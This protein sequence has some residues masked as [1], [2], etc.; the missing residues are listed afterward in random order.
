M[1]SASER[2]LAA[3]AAD[4]AIVVIDTPPGDLSIVRAAIRAGD[5]VLVPCQPAL[6][7]LDRLS[8]TLD[9]AT[10]AGKPAAVLLT[11]CRANTLSLAGARDALDNADLPVLT[12]VIPQREQ[13]A[14][15]Y[16]EPPSWLPS[17]CTEPCS[18][19]SNP[20]LP[21]RNCHSPMADL[22]TDDLKTKMMR[23]ATAPSPEAWGALAVQP[24]E[25]SYPRRVSLDVTDQMYRALKIRALDERTSMVALIRSI[26]ADHLAEGV[27]TPEA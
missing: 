2:R 12:A 27:N 22:K 4:Y 15:E 8:P 14:A 13:I 3:M 9:L 17:P 25:A 5:V 16:G 24:P 18:S 20:L 11:R 7:D 23:V 10:E 1:Y 19:S 6:M 21:E 26:L